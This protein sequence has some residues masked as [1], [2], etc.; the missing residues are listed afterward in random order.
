MFKKNH[1]T[2]LDDLYL[3]N[4]TNVDIKWNE[5][6]F[7]REGYELNSIEKEFYSANSVPVLVEER[8]TRRVPDDALKVQLQPLENGSYETKIRS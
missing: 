3:E 2:I 5:S 1:Y 4:S 8:Q 6:F 7:D